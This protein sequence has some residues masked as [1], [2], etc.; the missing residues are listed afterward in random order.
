[1]RFSLPVKNDGHTSG[2][3]A[4]CGNFKERD[5][6]SS[7]DLL[8]VFLRTAKYEIPLPIVV[9][10]GKNTPFSLT[11]EHGEVDTYGLTPVVLKALKGST[12]PAVC[13]CSLFP[14]TLYKLNYFF[15]DPQR[16][17]LNFSRY[18]RY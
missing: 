4:V 13:P 11:R 2:E 18:V 8:I 3:F 1:M 17:L 15:I 7:L 16:I 6:I 14:G 10:G 9:I 12:A 5:C